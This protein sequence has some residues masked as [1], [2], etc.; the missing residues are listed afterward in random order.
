M[1]TALGMIETNGWVALV[2]AADAMVKTADVSLIGWQKV[3]DGLVSVF[4]IGEVAS[5]QAAVDSGKEAGNDVGE[6][7]ASYVVP[8]IHEELLPMI[9][10]RSLIHS[11][12]D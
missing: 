8:R 3:G 1:S 5:V 10:L 6:V 12:Q 4:V 9:P 2:Q 11:I 7:C